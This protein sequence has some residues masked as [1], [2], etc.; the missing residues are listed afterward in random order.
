MVERPALTEDGSP[1]LWSATY[2]E[3]YHSQSGAWQEA[4]ER[5]V[6]PCRVESRV[7]GGPLRILD[8]GFGLGWNVAWTVH[9]ALRVRPDAEVEIVSFE[10]ELLPAAVLEPLWAEFPNPEVVSIL[11]GATAATDRR[12]ERGG[13]SLQLHI[14]PAELEIQ[15]VSGPFDC[16][17]LDPFSPGKNPE[18]WQVGFLREVFARCRD[19]AVLSTYS[20]ATRVK[21]A[22]L[23]AGWRIGPGPRVGKKSSGTVGARGSV[24]P[25]LPEFEPR[26]LRR[27]TKKAQ[28]VRR[29][30]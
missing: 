2:Q 29:N 16:V 6:V 25:P 4:R 23:A 3:H 27:L 22:L 7:R 8:V 21:V 1:T 13:I 26:E 12:W 30:E 28:E 10:K 17:F 14:G 5:Y 11:R 15:Q 19:G 18:L 20:A 9:E 24:E